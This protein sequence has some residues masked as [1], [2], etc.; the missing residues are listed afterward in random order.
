MVALLRS[1]NPVVIPRNHNV[2][3]ALEAATESGDYAVMQRL[4]RALVRPFED[5]SDNAAYREP[6]S[7]GRGVYQTFCGT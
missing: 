1:A 3:Q 4:L 2:E 7:P 6:P 5:T